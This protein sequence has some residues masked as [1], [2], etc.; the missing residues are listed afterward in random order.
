MICVKPEEKKRYQLRGLLV[1]NWAQILK[2]S[3]A[4]RGLS[5][6][7]HFVE[8]PTL[9]C[10]PALCLPSEPALTQ[11]FLESYFNWQDPGFPHPIGAVQLWSIIAALFSPIRKCLLDQSNSEDLESSFAWGWTNREPRV[12]TPVQISQLPSG[13]RG[14]SPLSTKD[15]ISPVKANQWG[16]Q[17]SCLVGEGPGPG[18]P[19][20]HAVFTAVLYYN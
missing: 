3:P 6:K 15:C 16:A 14:T 4:A 5:H 18:P 13:S 7:L 2:N 9:N 11:E 19:H 17:Q 1:A 10:L 8:K 12:G 20:S